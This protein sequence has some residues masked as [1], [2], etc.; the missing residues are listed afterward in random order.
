MSDQRANVRAQIAS[1]VSVQRRGFARRS[2]WQAVTSLA[3]GSLL[4]VGLCAHAAAGGSPVRLG[5]S[6][7][8]LPNG[9]I[10]LAGGYDN[11]HVPTADFFVT[12][13]TGRTTPLP[14]KM[15]YARAGH[16]STALPNGQVLIFGG[17][18]VNGRL[19][20]AGELLDM[21]SG[22]STLVSGFRLLPRAF[23]TATVL[24]DG[25]LVAIGGVGTGGELIPDI[26]VWDYRTGTTLAYDAGLS[27]PRWLHHATLLPNGNVL[28]SDGLDRVGKS[29]SVIEEYDP[30]AHRFSLDS[31]SPMAGELAVEG[32]IPLDGATD[33][34]LTDILA[35][36][37][38]SPMSVTGLNST[39]VTLKDS[40]GNWVPVGVN[41]AESGRLVF[42]SPLSPLQFGTTYI[43]TLSSLTDS[44]GNQLPTKTI[45]FTTQTDPQDPGSE[46]WIPGPSDFNGQ[47][48]S[49]TG[50]SEWQ[51]LPALQAK[52]GVNALAGQV[53]RLN[54][55]PLQHVLLQI[56]NR[57]AFTDQTGRFLVTNV[58]SGHHPLLIDGRTA[59]RPG[60]TY[61]LF[62]VGVDIVA[63]RTTAL[64]YTIW[65]TKLDTLHAVA[66]PSPTIAADTVVTTP[67]L[68]GLE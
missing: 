17:Y 33:V 41:A 29:S 54:G 56:D 20:S 48:H 24:T 62:E 10:L 4:L 19:V 47:W 21:A 51:K 68:P 6:L 66:I 53:L 2:A 38:G 8:L 12:D 45:Q 35:V 64:N 63:G 65:M 55:R 23:H 13:T 31:S 60:F 34:H 3:L 52:A 25:T 46:E 7:T 18:G 1:I 22:T 11:N 58:S 36:R 9:E 28:I 5:Q 50:P 57:S 43:L 40:S 30:S 27:V 44:S 49:H 59:N 32:S 67:V 42:A 14:V 39:N 26:Q 16:T 37:F 15:L 61:G